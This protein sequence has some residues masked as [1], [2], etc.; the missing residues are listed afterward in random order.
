MDSDGIRDAVNGANKGQIATQPSSSLLV[1]LKRADLGQSSRSTKKI[2]RKV[3]INTLNYLHFTGGYAFVR[4]TFRLT[5]EEFL[6]KVHPGPCIED[7][8]SLSLMTDNPLDL[9]GFELKSLVVD[10]GQSVM[11]IPVESV[12][13]SGSTFSARLD[14]KGIMYTARNAR[15]FQ[16]PLVDA[17]IR[18]GSARISG[19]LVDFTS[20][21]LRIRFNENLGGVKASLSLDKEITV[22]LCNQGQVVFSGDCQ[23]VRDEPGDD[24]MI[25]RPTQS[26]QARFKERKLRNPRLC[27]VPTPKISFIHPFS[28]RRVSYEVS[29]ITNLGFSV[30]EASDKGQLIPGMI[31]PELAILYSGGLKLK[32]SA[33]VVYT[34]KL[35]KN[36]HKHGF[37]IYDLD[38]VTYNQFFDIYGNAIDRHANVTR[39]VDM[40]A[41]W[42]FFFESGFIYPKKY[43]SLSNHKEEFKQTYEILYHHSP[44][45]F[46]NFTYQHNGM[47]YGHV[48]IIKAYDRTWMIHHLAAKPMGRKRTGLLVLNHILNYFDGLYRIPSIGMNYMI[49]YFRPENKFPDYFFGGFSRELNNPK[50]C[51][52][53]CFAYLTC[54]PTSSMSD[55]PLDWLLE[56]C[57]QE[58][59]ACL[60]SEYDRL[61]GGLMIDALCLDSVDNRSGSIEELYRS[62]GLKRRS[63]AYVL[64]NKGVS[65]AFLIVDESNMGINLSELLNS[66]KVVVT[67]DGVIPW[68]V[69][70]AALYK[71]APV[72]GAQK[73]P[74]LI[75]PCTYL[76]DRNI[77]FEKRYNFWV[78]DARFG[79]D[80]TE[81]LKEK[82]KIRFVKLFV[83]YLLAKMRGK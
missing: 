14:V 45:V 44:E 4:M 42:E 61:S 34:R 77:K 30:L 63:I 38:L 18:Q 28:Y 46:A 41:L 39:E 79:D 9:E 7:V 31:I 2:P 47:I 49:F 73:F 75:Y 5:G 29:D 81:H 13:L 60:R 40:E 62:C 71:L 11:S 65:K 78:L 57:S 68:K 69:F 70:Q 64:K 58:D 50:G 16:S 27:L 83:K 59:I 10:D 82:A 8:V 21:G 66:I 3:F 26:Q 15:R 72:Y 37:A 74:V 12:Q 19:C 24:S 67:D 36:M 48:S 23:Y 54:T 80:Y 25:L 53:D 22:N 6:L 32:C 52:M 56:E 76:E 17:A 51:S 20:S 55:L 1:P 43:E 35:K 33:Q